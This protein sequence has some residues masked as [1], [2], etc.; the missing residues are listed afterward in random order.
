MWVNK[1][2]VFTEDK[3]REFKAS[4]P[5]A[6]THIRGSLVAKSLHPSPSPLSQLL[7]RHALHYM[8]SNGNNDLAQ[9]Y[10]AGAIA[11]SPVPFSQEHPINTPVTVPIPIIDFTTLQPLCSDTPVFS[12]RPVTA[13]SSA[14]DVAAMF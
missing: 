9:E 3:V 8:S 10:P 6:E 1:D 2:D 7:Y 14:S 5:D 11:D 13:S 4:N 12:P